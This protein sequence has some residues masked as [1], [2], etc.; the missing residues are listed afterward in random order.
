MK[1]FSRDEV[2]W[3][4]DAIQKGKLLPRDS[5]VYAAWWE[6]VGSYYPGHAKCFCE[7]APELILL[8]FEANGGL[9]DPFTDEELFEFLDGIKPTPF[10]SYT[11][12]MGL[13]NANC[14]RN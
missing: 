12:L 8:D 3:E 6:S 2:L 9:T 1:E 4:A 11:S 7:I 10:S 14:Y 5:E 13:S